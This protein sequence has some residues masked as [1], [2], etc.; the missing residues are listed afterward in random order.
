MAPNQSKQLAETTTPFVVTP[1]ESVCV[2]DDR[3][4][5]SDSPYPALS[6]GDDEERD[7]DTPAPSSSY[8]DWT[9]RSED[10]WAWPST[11]IPSN[12]RAKHVEKVR[13]K[14]AK[15]A[16]LAR[17]RRNDGPTGG[18]P[19]N[20]YWDW[21]AVAFNDQ[22]PTV[23][24]VSSSTSRPA[25]V[26][27]TTT[28]ETKTTTETL[29]TTESKDES[30]KKTTKEDEEQ[31]HEPKETEEAPVVTPDQDPAEDLIE[32]DKNDVLYNEGIEHLGIVLWSDAQSY[33]SSSLTYKSNTKDPNFN[34]GIEHLGIILSKVSSDSLHSPKDDPDGKK[35]NASPGRRET[36]MAAAIVEGIAY[37]DWPANKSFQQ[38]KK[39][40]ARSA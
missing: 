30:I 14:I 17:D 35:R 10:Y 11:T 6:S 13:Q 19:Y 39:L 26:P 15:A 5:A 38:R 18:L 2:Q 3:A 1:N 25:A 12:V 7:M 28:Q 29:T 36:A 21:S 4:V 34:D 31:Q 40:A 27:T 33:P 16:A 8:W 23:E 37:W 9:P 22:E 24:V 20:S 32:E